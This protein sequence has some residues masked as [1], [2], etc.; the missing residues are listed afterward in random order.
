M[1][2]DDYL[3]AHD[4]SNAEFARRL[5]EHG[6]RATAGWIRQI[7]QGK[8]EAGRKL[9]LHIEA[10]TDG[11]VTALEILGF[12]SSDSPDTAPAGGEPTASD[13]AATGEAA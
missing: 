4:L 12:A 11:Q 6:A 8:K 13:E 9:A 5:R 1:R 3:Q 2:L 7:R 10:V